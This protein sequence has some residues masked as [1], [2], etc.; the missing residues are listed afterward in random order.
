MPYT[1]AISPVSNSYLTKGKEYEIVE[2][3]ECEIMLEGDSIGFT[4]VD[5]D[6]DRIYCIQHE[7]GHLG[8]LSWQLK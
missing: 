3:D 6:G 7:D 1:K 8:K 4:I 2:S 5:D